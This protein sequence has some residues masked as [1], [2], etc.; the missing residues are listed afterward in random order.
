MNRALGEIVLKETKESYTSPAEEEQ[1][2]LQN[3]Y[4]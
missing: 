3:Q 4:S 1:H 2:R